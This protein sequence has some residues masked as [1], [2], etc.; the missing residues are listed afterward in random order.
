MQFRIQSDIDKATKA[1]GRMKKQIPFAASVAMNKTVVD[2]QKVEKAA[3]V[4]ELDRPRPGTIKAIRV[5]RSNKRRLSASVFILPA[6]DRFIRYQVE[7]GTRPPR[8]KAEAVPVDIRLNKY[9]NI[10]GR[11]SGKLSKLLAR[12]DTFSATIKGVAGIWQRA[13][14]RG[15]RTGLTLLAAFESQTTYRPRFKFYEHAERT[16]ARRWPRNFNRA[17]SQAIRTA[18]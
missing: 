14:G 16:A 9:G 3:I 10:A 5:S 18:R 7:G 6:V 1:L 13:K 12:P 8:G 15:R 11:R 4:R 2:I 17:I